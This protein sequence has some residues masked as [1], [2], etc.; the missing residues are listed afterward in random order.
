MS[1]SSRKGLGLTT[2]I[3]YLTFV[4]AGIDMSILAQYKSQLAQQ[5]TNNAGDVASVYYVIGAVGL[6]GLI[7]SIFTGP[8]SDFFGHRLS[9]LIG[10]FGFAL[11][12]FGIIWSPSTAWGYFFAMVCGIANSFM[13]ASVI[14]VLID[15]YPK[16]G[17][18]VTMMTKFF[19]SVGQFLLPPIM[20][21]VAAAHMSFHATFWG[22]GIVTAISAC[23]YFGVK[24]PNEPNAEER[25]KW[26]EQQKA[27]REKNKAE[28]KAS[29]PVTA[30]AISIMLIGFTSFASFNLWA[31]CYQ[32]LAKSYG[33]AQPQWLQ[34]IY[35]ICSLLGVLFNSWIIKK[36]FKESSILILY[37]L[38]TAVSL[39]LSLIHNAGLLYVI[40]GLIGFFAA[41]GLMQLATAL[42]SY[43][44]PD[45]KGTTTSLVSGL[46]VGLASYGCTSVAGL[47]MSHFGAQGGPR[48]IVIFNIVITLI[49]SCL[50][51]IVRHGENKRRAET[52]NK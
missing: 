13:S 44:Y 25:K 49:G 24:F 30:E 6:G 15:S 42:M 51:M 1:D 18:I 17:S 41:S 20:A 5:W 28:G 23:F 50:G 32:E 19:V 40:A 12:A 26:R 31:N 29:F 4:L 22:L 2:F 16:S 9:A 11:F 34:Q 39:A 3:N 43:L 10:T 8:I 45:Y 33:V 52:A 46:M 36:G 35:A 21:W 14:P 38:I 47:M 27:E 37:P 7:S 48:A